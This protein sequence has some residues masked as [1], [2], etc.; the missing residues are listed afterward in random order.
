MELEALPST[1]AEDPL[2]LK[3]M[4]LAIHDVMATC[5]QVSPYAVMPENIPSITQVS[6]S[7]S[8]PTMP[9]SLEVAST[10]PTPQL[11]APS[12]ADP[13]NKG[14][15]VFQLQGEMNTALEQL[16]MTKATMDSH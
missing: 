11:Q 3:G 2:G 7:P 9:R 1:R 12:R 8:P 4:D 16:L 10:S 14:Y 5:L 6:H 13:A 15:E